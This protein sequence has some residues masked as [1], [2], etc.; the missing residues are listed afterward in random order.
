MLSTDECRALCGFPKSFKFVGKTSDLYAQV[1][2]GVCPPVARWLADQF[3]RAVSKGT[4]ISIPV[5]TR[6][7]V[8]RGKIKLSTPDKF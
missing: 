3:Y 8:F 6:V 5:R 4:P 7:D 2:K 1:G